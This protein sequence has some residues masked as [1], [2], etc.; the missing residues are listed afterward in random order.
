MRSND[1]FFGYNVIKFVSNGVWCI[2]TV[3]TETNKITLKNGVGSWQII[4]TFVQDVSNLSCMVSIN[5]L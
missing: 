1:D 5:V 4:E 2:L 3:T